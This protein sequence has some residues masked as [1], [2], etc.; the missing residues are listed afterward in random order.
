MHGF[1]AMDWKIFLYIFNIL[2]QGTYI[3]WNVCGA[4]IFCARPKINGLTEHGS[5]MLLHQTAV[6]PVH[7]VG[8]IK[9]AVL[10]R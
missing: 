4:Y 9:W 5:Y 1:L 8:K 3:F 6:E 2:L 7:L 10:R